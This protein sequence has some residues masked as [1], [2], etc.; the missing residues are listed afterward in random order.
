MI[1]S[2]TNYFSLTL[3]PCQTKIQKLNAETAPVNLNFNLIAPSWPK[4]YTILTFLSAIGVKA[5]IP[6]LFYN[7]DDELLYSHS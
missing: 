1:H 2:T 5:D 3:E 4:L 6:P 7:S